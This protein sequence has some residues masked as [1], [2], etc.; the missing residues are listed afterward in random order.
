MVGAWL[1]VAGGSKATSPCVEHEPAKLSSASPLSAGPSS[2]LRCTPCPIRITPKPWYAGGVVRSVA[3]MS[4]ASAEPAAAR[5]VV[6]ACPAV[7]SSVETAIFV[8]PCGVSN[9]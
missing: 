3:P 1:L 7:R 4:F 9:Q 8:V 6:S 5:S 2:C